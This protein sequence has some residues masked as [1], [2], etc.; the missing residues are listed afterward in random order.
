MLVSALCSLLTLIALSGPPGDEGRPRF[1]FQSFGK[2]MLSKVKVVAEAEATSVILA[3]RGV[4]VAHFKVLEM[5]RG[6]VRGKELVVL[7]APGQFHSGATYLLFLDRFHGGDRL[8]VLNRIAKGERDYSAKLKV[9][10]QYLKAD[11]TADPHQRALVIR[12]LLV[13]NLAATDLFIRW[14]ALTELAPFVEK[15]MAMFGPEQKA[16][17]VEAYRRTPSAS[18]R[19]ELGRILNRLGIRI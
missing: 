6:E 15:H 7:T 17:M 1:E 11:A 2:D 3:G 19:R 5:L 14:N 13:E 8:T 9:A 16:Q 18:F 10:R 4:S 12:T